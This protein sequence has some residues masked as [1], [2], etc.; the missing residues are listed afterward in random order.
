MSCHAS[1]SRPFA[2]PGHFALFAL[3]WLTLAAACAPQPSIEAPTSAPANTYFPIA[4]GDQML[5][6]QLALNPAEQAKGLMHRDTLGE[7]QGMLFL[8]ETP[9]QRGFWMRNTRIPLD[10][11]Y[12]DASGRLREV[13]PLYPFDETTVASVSPEILIAVET[14][15][16]WFRK[17][18]VTPGARLD[19]TALWQAVEARGVNHP[20]KPD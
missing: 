19:M 5:H 13:Y 11:G 2:S 7:Q 17:H 8:F 1:N 10:I 4:L 12:F 6:L 15:Q 14:N 20:L 16:G 9:D 18:G 3:F